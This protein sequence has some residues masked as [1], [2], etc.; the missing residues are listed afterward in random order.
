MKKL[1]QLYNNYIYPIP[2]DKCA[3]LS[4][5]SIL[6]LIP[7]LYILFY[8]VQLFHIS[9]PGLRLFLNDIL[10]LESVNQIIDFVIY[11]SKT[12]F[13]SA[14]IVIIS[15]LVIISNG[16]YVFVKYINS[17]FKF[18]DMSA[19]KLRIRAF[20]IAL[21]LIL[22]LAFLLIALMIILPILTNKLPLFLYYLSLFLIYVLIHF[23]VVL[24]LLKFCLT[25]NLKLK[26]L[27][28]G[29][30]LFSVSASFIYLLFSPFIKIF[31]NNYS[32]YGPLAG[33]ASILIFFYIYFVLLLISVNLILITYKNN[34]TPTVSN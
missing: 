11:Q 2:L 6:A 23:I 24:L 15:S 29:M 14:I 3:A 28:K 12:S 16:V 18:K 25:K 30:L 20:F 9:L 10:P 33:F 5:Y 27:W 1:I 19:L 21:L 26:I 4:Y 31:A 7:G 32:S 34:L 13:V 17:L 22:T 8:C